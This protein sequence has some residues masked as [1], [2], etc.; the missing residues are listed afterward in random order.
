MIE[1]AA[2]GQ[3]LGAL[4]GYRFERDLRESDDRLARY[5]LPIRRIAPV[6]PSVEPEGTGPQEAITARDVVD[7]VQLLEL[8][9]EDRAAVFTRAAVA[10]SDRDAVA[11]VLDSLA[12]TY[13]AVGD[14][15]VAESVYQTVL[16]NYERAGAAMAAIDKQQRPPDPQVIRTPRT[17]TRYT[18]KVFALS[19]EATAR[20]PWQAL[21]DDRSAAAPELNAW[22]ST[23]L[24]DPADIRLWGLLTTQGRDKPASIR[25]DALGLSPLSLVVAAAVGA[26]DA[27]SELE[28][29]IAHA[30]AGER[31]VVAGDRLEVLDGPPDGQPSAR[32]E[33]IALA[34]LR[35]L[36]GWILELLTN[37]RPLT[38][39]DFALPGG[40]RASG[41]DVQE[42]VRRADTAVA[43]LD[44]ALAL[45]A[46]AGVENATVARIR[47][48]LRA[49]AALGIP[50][51]VPRTATGGSAAVR[52]ALRD[53][54][55]PAQAVLAERRTR[56]DGLGAPPAPGPDGTPPP[57]AAVVSHHTDRLR[58][59]FGP[60][61][62]VVPRIQ[63]PTPAAAACSASLADA[64]ALTA[65]DALA[66][67]AWVDRM[68]LVRPGTDRL[69]R[70]L[71]AA[72]TLDAP[73]GAPG[74]VAV[75][76]LP[77][78]PAQRWLALPFAASGPAEATVALALHGTVDLAGPLAGVVCDEWVETIPGAVETTGVTFHYDAPGARAQQCVLLVVP[79][80]ATMPT[81][82]LDT[83]LDTVGEAAELTRLRGVTTKQMT[84]MGTQLPTVYLPDNFTRDRP[85]V[86]F[87]KLLKTRV[88]AIQHANVIG[89]G[90][91][92]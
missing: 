4:L 29:R 10:V 56:V 14:V 39:E 40:D 34:E 87:G 54:L 78:T 89:K 90:W 19:S 65:G 91:S 33:E 47:T 8:W 51:A 81:W 5:L 30:L 66:P 43:A 85:S 7:G 41:I 35:V 59:V 9:R 74:D 6:R 2:A 57:E 1:G 58:T 68:S 21:R 37:C 46:S 88:D 32:P 15:L 13:D 28:H 18:Q 75:L 20:G 49:A 50:E 3:P 38:A 67:R 92:L 23:L 86:D 22:V 12:S 52:N 61:F 27:P 53:Q 82:D 60:A 55:G 11:A 77:H 42:L 16:G 63:V 76:Q 72:E 26:V 36:T 45:A 17:G 64:T 70:V 25:A 24:P 80:S 79:P 69:A 48:A 84:M 71:T 44:S 83:L 62:P 31:P 73:G